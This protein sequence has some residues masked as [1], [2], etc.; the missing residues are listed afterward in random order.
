LGER[1]DPSELDSGR[2]VDQ[3]LEGDLSDEDPLAKEVASEDLEIANVEMQL[4]ATKKRGGN[5]I[6]KQNPLATMI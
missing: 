3:V 6:R 1:I 5:R 4:S 2:N